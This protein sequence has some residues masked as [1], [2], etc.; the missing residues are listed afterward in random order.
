MSLPVCLDTFCKAGGAGVGYHRAGYRVVGVDIEPQPHYPFEFIQADAI[1]FIGDRGH[2]YDLIHA[3]PPC[4]AYSTTA[5]LST[6][7][8]PRLIELTRAALIASGR[9][10]VIENV[11]G[12]PLINPLV[13]C[14]TMFGLRVIR[15]RLFEC[16][17]VVWFPPMACNHWGKVAPIWWQELPRGRTPSQ[18]FFDHYDFITIS[19]KNFLARDIERA[20]GINWMTVEEAAQAIPPAY[21]EF[22]GRQM[23]KYVRSN[24]PLHLTSG[25]CAPEINLNNNPAC[26]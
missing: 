2:E 21:T 4:Q 13:L 26:R 17:P 3:S 5:S 25:D 15:H 19:G 10:Y 8:H 11:P 18:S 9:P 20:M 1:E 23:L 24:N 16:S 14:G 6:K 7:Q 22:I 12:A